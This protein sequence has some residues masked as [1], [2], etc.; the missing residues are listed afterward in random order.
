MYCYDV[1]D[2]KPSAMPEIPDLQIFSRNVTRKLGGKT[3][4]RVRILRP[5]RLKQPE[6]AFRKRLEGKVL[7]EVKREGKE[8]W[9]HMGDGTIWSLHLMLHGELEFFD[10]KSE[11]PKTTI[12][13]LEFDD[14]PGLRIRDF[15]GMALPSLDP[16][17][18]PG[19]DALSRGLNATYLK[20]V[21]KSPSMVKNLLLDQDLIRGIGNAYVD[22]MLWHARISPFSIAGKVPDDRIEVLAKTI[23]SVLKSAEKHILKLHPDHI[24]GEIRDFLVVHN[25]KKEKSPGGATIHV[26][27]AGSRKTYYTDEQVLYK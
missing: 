3:I 23:K 5:K 10:K 22:E 4:R 9:F 6:S 17:P 13:E 24:T 19:V 25:W 21:F 14:A 2:L 16:V 1:T 15:H 8:L 12:M 26:H 7:K 18:K 27:K 20:K 11:R